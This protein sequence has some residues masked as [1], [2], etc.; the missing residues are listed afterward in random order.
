M[1]SFDITCRGWTF[2]FGRNNFRHLLF[3]NSCL[4]H[5]GYFK[6]ISIFMIRQGRDK[7]TVSNTVAWGVTTFGWWDFRLFR[8]C[9]SH[10]L[11]RNNFFGSLGHLKDISKITFS[12]YEDHWNKI[13]SRAEEWGL[14]KPKVGDKYL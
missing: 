1:Y 14:Y 11:F 7:W 6:D 13:F 5:L 2:W 8:R 10:F 4:W 12:R 9:Y 3:R